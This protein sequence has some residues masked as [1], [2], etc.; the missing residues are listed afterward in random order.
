MEM[1]N[2]IFTSTHPKDELTGFLLKKDLFACLDLFIET[3]KKGDAIFSLVLLDVD[4]FKKINDRLGHLAGD[5]V[6]QY[7]ASMLKLSIEE[8]SQFFF[9]YGGDEFIILLPGK[10][11]REALKIMTR[12]KRA[13]AQRPFMFKNRIMKM[14]ASIGAAVFSED[15]YGGEE[16]IK[17]ADEAMYFSKHRGRNIATAANNMNYI[18]SLE[19]FL[20]SV[21]FIFFLLFVYFNREFFRLAV[22]PAA[23][24][25]AKSIK[26]SVFS[27][28]FDKV[29]L[30]D[31]SVYYGRVVRE[32]HRTLEF[33][34]PTDQGTIITLNIEKPE[35]AKLQYGIMTSSRQKYRDYLA[36]NPNPHDM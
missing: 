19:M 36:S 6:L 25:F 17:R 4:R 15:G 35:V 8:F 23:K 32:T 28:K 29:V 21:L 1:N 24:E 16:L 27:V 31:G 26:E 30:R 33:S 13:M 34:I 10:N 11:S 7:M 5:K 3:A 2:I 22:V 18:K 20:V 14:T 9:R 12:F